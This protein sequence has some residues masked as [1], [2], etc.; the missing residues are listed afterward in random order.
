[1]RSLLV[2][3]L[4]EPW[5]PAV[6]G[7][8]QFDTLQDYYQRAT[9]T[10][11]AAGWAGDIWYHDGFDL[12]ASN[13]VDFLGPPQYQDIYIDTHQYLCFGGPTENLSAWGQIA[14]T[15]QQEAPSLRSHGNADWVIVGE[16]SLAIPSQ[17]SPPYPYSDDALMYYRALAEAQRQAYGSTGDVTNS[18][19]KGSFFWNFKTESSPE[20]DFL[21]GVA[22]GY[23]P[24]TFETNNATFDCTAW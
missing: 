5:T 22:Q 7:P 16:W 4:N 24:T 21:N 3:L 1:M 2:Q 20:W 11:R 12:G 18:P 13:W 8:V 15:C 17:V 10:L 14:Y 19:V 6:G 23:M 9:D